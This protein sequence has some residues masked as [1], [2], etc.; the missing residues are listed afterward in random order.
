MRD[1]DCKRSF[2][3]IVQPRKKKSLT[4]GFF[5]L[6]RL[7]CPLVPLPIRT[8][9]VE[10]THLTLTVILFKVRANNSLILFL[11]QTYAKKFAEFRFLFSLYFLDIAQGIL[12][13]TGTETRQVFSRMFIMAKSFEELF[14]PY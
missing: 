3:F 11:L 2:V 10:D 7:I 14:T 6:Y 12:D 13:S 1:Q 9:V 5:G 8:T 4:P